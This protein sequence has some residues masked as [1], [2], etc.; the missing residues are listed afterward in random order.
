MMYQYE[1]YLVLG[2]P[3]IPKQLQT[4]VES[5]GAE[6]QGQSYRASHKGPA[7]TW[8]SLCFREPNKIEA[9]R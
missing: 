4:I 5:T 1:A 9:L 7:T 2:S 6:R 3:S 8:A